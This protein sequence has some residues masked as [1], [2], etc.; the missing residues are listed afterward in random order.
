MIGEVKISEGDTRAMTMDEIDRADEELAG[1]LDGAAR[2]RGVTVGLPNVTLADAVLP[3]ELVGR[4]RDAGVVEA[5]VE[6]R[7]IPAGDRADVPQEATPPRALPSAGSDR[8]RVVDE[9]L[10]G[11]SHGLAVLWRL[12]RPEDRAHLAEEVDVLAELVPELVAS[13]GALQRR[14]EPAEEGR[15]A[16]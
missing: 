9:L 6:S 10:E 15:W 16:P 2:G 13:L 8:D 12:L 14:R 11:R 4:R 7:A 5:V 1:G 3:L